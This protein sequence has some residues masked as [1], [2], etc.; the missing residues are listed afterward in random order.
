MSFPGKLI[1]FFF[2]L[3]VVVVPL[4]FLPNTSELFEFNKMIVTYILTLL[5]VTAWISRMILEKRLIFNRTLLDWPI[6]IFLIT[7]SLS[8]LFSIDPRTSLMGYYSRFNGGIL[9]LL[10]YSLLYWSAVSNLDKKS[11]LSIVNW[12]LLTAAVV[13]AWGFLEHFGIDSHLWVQDV[14]T[15]VFSTL[16]QPNWLAAYLIALIFIPISKLI[17]KIRWWPAFL[18]LLLFLVLLYTKSRSGLMAFA[19]CFVIFWIAY[20]KKLGKFEIRSI[21]NLLIISLLTLTLTLTIK[22]PIRDMVITSPP[23]TTSAPASGTSLESGGTESGTIRKI[24]W[25]GAVRIWK[26]GPKNFWL[27][28]GPETFAMAYY[29]FRPI[30]HNNTSEWE[31]LYNKAHN[32]FLNYLSTTGIL[33]FSSYLILLGFMFVTFF[34]SQK[35]NNQSS[36]NKNVENH[37]AIDNWYLIISL[38]AGWLTI[39]ITNF[40]GFSV[41]IVQI[42]LFLF[43]AFTITLNHEETPRKSIPQSTWQYLAQLILYSSALLLFSSICNYWLADV[44]YADGQKA[45]RS[46]NAT[47][48]PEYILT[49][50]QKFSRSYELNSVDSPISS[51]LGVTAAFMSLLVSQNDTDASG[52]FIEISQIASKKAIENSPYHPNYY[53]SRSRALVV[54][55]TMDSR[56]FK[57]SDEALA[58]AQTISPTDP[59]IPYI[60]A[61]NAKYDNQPEL[62]KKYYEEALK[63]KP[64]FADA[65]AQLQQLATPSSVPSQ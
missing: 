28:S 57:E 46:F 22:N 35:P 59:R 25:T 3:L 5:I 16:G 15:R 48:D 36:K 39:S 49:A 18:S 29:Q 23:Q 40:W 42:F 53:K 8:L 17:S 32:E 19:V 37:L 20:L 54:L 51:E 9:S 4:I 30:E 31:L 63:L 50:Y 47:Q 33:G 56:Y 6:L 21:K 7:Q 44:A 58:H 34:K 12:S 13:A 61:I 2:T 1:Q 41:V 60:R 14:K 10:C 38:L 62:A 52:Q 11:T 26:S 55:G 27:G 64:D 24:V 65:K 45:F 43:P